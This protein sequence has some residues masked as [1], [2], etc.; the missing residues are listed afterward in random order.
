[1]HLCCLKNARQVPAHCCLFAL[2]LSIELQTREL[3]SQVRSGVYAHLAAFFP[4]SKD[5]LVK[6]ARKLYLYEQVSGF[7]SAGL[8]RVRVSCDLQSVVV[9]L[10]RWRSP[11]SVVQAPRLAMWVK[12][13]SGLDLP[14]LGVLVWSTAC[15]TS[16]CSVTAPGW[17]V[18]GTS[19]EAKGSHWKGHAG[20]DGQVPGGMPSPYTGQ[21]CQVSSSSARYASV[22][23]RSLQRRAT[24]RQFTAYFCTEV[25]N[26]WQALIGLIKL[27][28]FFAIC[29]DANDSSV[30]GTRSWLKC[31]IAVR[32]CL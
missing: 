5:T 25:K 32:A 14:G 9:W 31:F 10:T 20:A 11:P 6:R 8:S 15:G 1:M 26:C 21:V 2:I 29:G 4:C 17:P 27:C 30:D 18:E 22:A 12:N 7:C 28:V 3:S 13:W 19:P 23:H 24:L 16:V